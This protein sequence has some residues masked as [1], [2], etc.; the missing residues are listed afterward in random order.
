VRP[1]TALRIPSLAASPGTRLHYWL[2]GGT[3][4]AV[5][6]L[7]ERASF[8]EQLDGIGITLWSPS[9]G[10][11]V[12]FLLLAG[13]RFTPFIFLASVITDFAIYSGPR[14]LL[15]PIATSVVLAIGFTGLS[16]VLEK[17]W[18]ARKVGLSRVLVFLAVVPVGI[19]LLA[20]AYCFVLYLC[21]ILFLDRFLIALRNFW[22][23]NTLGIITL[24]PAAV[25]VLRA[26]A[27]RRS[28]PR[29]EL[30]SAAI[31]AALLIAAL[32]II[33]GLRRAHEYQLFYL[34]FIPV[35]WIAVRAGY[36]GVSL[37]LPVVH[38][39]IVR[40]ATMLGYADYDFI[41]FQMLML[42]LSATGLLLGAAVTEARS[43]AE[44]MRLRET[45]LA[46]ATRQALV[47]ATGTAVAHEISQPLAATT[48]YLH[49]ARRMLLAPDG[50]RR[51]EAAAALAKAETEARRVRE[52][53]ERV[54]EYVASGRLQLSDVDLEAVIAKIVTLIRHDALERGVRIETSTKPYLPTVRG[55][56]IQ[57]EQ[58]F[59]NLIWNAVD[60]ASS[61]VT[62]NCLQRADRLVIE[63]QDNGPGVSAAVADR[64]FEP[65][66]S[67][68]LNGMGLGLTL[69]RQIVDAHAGA[70]TW[71]NLSSGGARFTVELR[72]DGP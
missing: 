42:V 41:A 46:R 31:F 10:A 45:E 3:F 69:V 47:G 67:T 33:F 40:I 17:V 56:A 11:S 2:W 63:V 57:L 16:R 49:A 53:L 27:D 43:S 9:A 58:L 37:A 18:H 35:V 30:V 12:V 71:S 28:L 54:R 23:G 1:N 29:R 64:L 39:L 52:T 61:M 32:W 14:G 44:R 66:E 25:S 38:L 55:D 72:I 8:L 59:L 48:N 26:N 70:L 21:G 68:K 36:A 62:V 15:A 65:F 34:L 22:I 7:I 50:D 5:Y 20:F 19:L 60:A 13:V 51:A 6:F 24:V 4:A